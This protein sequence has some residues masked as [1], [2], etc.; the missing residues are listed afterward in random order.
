[1][2]LNDLHGV[3]QVFSGRF[4]NDSSAPGLHTVV[5]RDSKPEIQ[6]FECPSVFLFGNPIRRSVEICNFTPY[7]GTSRQFDLSAF[8]IKI[9]SRLP[10]IKKDTTCFCSMVSE[11]SVSPLLIEKSWILLSYPFACIST[12]RVVVPAL[13]YAGVTEHHAHSLS[14]KF[15]SMLQ[16]AFAVNA[17]VFVIASELAKRCVS[18]SS[19]FISDEGLFPLFPPFPLLGSE[20]TCSLLQAPI[21]QTARITTHS[22]DFF[23]AI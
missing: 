7:G 20:S 15:W 23:I 17:T 19:S 4:Q 2:V 12:V 6:R 5:G 1:M 16:S 11:I 14:V 10:P 3:R 13:P 22:I 8:V 9:N 18:E 21:M